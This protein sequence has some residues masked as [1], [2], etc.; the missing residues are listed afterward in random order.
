MPHHD[1]LTY[2]STVAM[3]VPTG[4]PAVTQHFRAAPCPCCTLVNLRSVLYVSHVQ[5]DCAVNL[6]ASL[7]PPQNAHVLRPPHSISSAPRSQYTEQSASFKTG[8]H[9]VN[10]ANSHC[11][12]I[13]GYRT[14]QSNYSNLHALVRPQDMSAQGVV[15]RERAV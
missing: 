8:R 14:H 2:S 3:P 4:I 10:D 7:S 11:C 1:Y 5:V 9:Q 6:A 15:W 12:C 13:A